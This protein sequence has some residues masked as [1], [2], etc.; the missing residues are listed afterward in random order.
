M[1]CVCVCVCCVFESPCVVCESSYV[2]A[3]VC[4]CV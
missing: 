1:W 2:C 3:V 4:V